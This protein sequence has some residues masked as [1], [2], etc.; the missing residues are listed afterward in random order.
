MLD[1]LHRGSHK[2]STK[3]THCSNYANRP[4]LAPSTA[5][6]A[7]T[8]CCKRNSLDS[9][10]QLRLAN[11]TC[12]WRWRL[13]GINPAIVPNASKD[14]SALRVGWIQHYPP[15][16]HEL[17]SRRQRATLSRR[18]W[19]N[20]ALRILNLEI[21]HLNHMTEVSIFFTNCLIDLYNQSQGEQSLRIQQ[22][23]AYSRKSLHFKT[24]KTPFVIFRT[25]PAKQIHKSTFS[26]VSIPSSHLCLVLPSDFFPSNI[27][28]T[29]FYIKI[30]TKLLHINTTSP[31]CCQQVLWTGNWRTVIISYR[32]P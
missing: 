24:P 32:W 31:T 26:S 13:C 1:N 3:V 21:L 12:V 2:P 11:V 27:T 25:S 4:T 10:H 7:E 8:Q 29:S 23:R 30:T 6:A 5:L 19:G 14:G 16:C 20:T 9:W 22:I 17:R 28:A 18:F 15:K